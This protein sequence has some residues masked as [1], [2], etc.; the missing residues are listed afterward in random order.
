MYIHLLVLLIIGLP[1]L[2]IGSLQILREEFI[3]KRYDLTGKGEV[4]YTKKIYYD[5]QNVKMP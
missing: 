2:F 4:K 3:R 5:T 1:Y